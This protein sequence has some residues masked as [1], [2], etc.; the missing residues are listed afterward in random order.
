MY[1]MY[2][3]ERLFFFFSRTDYSAHCGFELNE[4][5]QTNKTKKER[6]WPAREKKEIAGK[7][8]KMGKQCGSEV[9]VCLFLCCLGTG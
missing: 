4:C 6:G 9:C 7:R 1:T 2:I 8:K 3:F 5:R